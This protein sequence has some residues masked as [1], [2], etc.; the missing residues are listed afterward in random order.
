MG[1]LRCV[2]RYN[3]DTSGE[4]VLEKSPAVSRNNLGV[5]SSGLSLSNMFPVDRRSF[6]EYHRTYDIYIMSGRGSLIA[7][8]SVTSRNKASLHY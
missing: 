3:I 4:D 2:W 8:D 6:F 1:Y 7:T 5:K